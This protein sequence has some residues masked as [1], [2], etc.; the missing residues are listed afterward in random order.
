MYNYLLTNLLTYSHVDLV[1]HV[2]L[3]F[4]I[5]ITSKRLPRLISYSARK[6]KSVH[7]FCFH[8]FPAPKSGQPN[9]SVFCVSLATGPENF[10]KIHGH[11]FKLL[12]MF[13]KKQA[14]QLD[15]VTMLHVEGNGCQ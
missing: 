12:C 8:D 4:F 5:Q 9:L 2:R 3:W 1:M 14:T 13:T 6:T 15:H 7:I 10:T 11:L